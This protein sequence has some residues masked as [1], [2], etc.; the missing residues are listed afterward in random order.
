MTPTQFEYA[1][2]DLEA[3]D[4][5]VAYHAWILDLIEPFLGKRIVEVGAGAGSFSELLLT[6]RPDSLTLVEPSS[7]F[8]MLESTFEGR[9]TFTKTRLYNT[10]F[11]EV[12]SEI[13]STGPPDSVLYINVL[14]HIEDDRGELQLVRET[15]APNGRAFVFVPA[16]PMLF[17]NYDKHIGHFRRYGRRELKV[18][19]KDAGFKV[20]ILRWFDM[21]GILPW[22]L[23][24]RLF[25]SLKMETAAVQTYDR[26]AVPIIRPLETLIHP[27]VGKNLLLVAERT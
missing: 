6:L 25:G 3:M 4:F 14:E 15:L 20:L 11:S 5:A 27:P 9:E 26:L 22:L 16:L 19:C 10:V 23:K 2:K 1:G 13:Y 7:M 17:S 24:Y 8:R 21:I 12:A 18:K